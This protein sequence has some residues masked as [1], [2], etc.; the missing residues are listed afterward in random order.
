MM[1]RKQKKRQG[2]L[3]DKFDISEAKVFQY[4]IDKSQGSQS[5]AGS[6]ES[7]APKMVDDDE[8]LCRLSRR[9]CLSG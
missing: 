9:E 4:C 2:S 5:E 1:Q 3:E 8:K 6:V 7:S